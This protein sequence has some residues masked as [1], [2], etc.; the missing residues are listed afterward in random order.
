MQGYT[1]EKYNP[2]I[3]VIYIKHKNKL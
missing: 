3:K 2:E 1:Y